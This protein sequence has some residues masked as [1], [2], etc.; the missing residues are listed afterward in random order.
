MNP[1]SREITVT[2][3]DETT[4]TENP[5]NSK[6]TYDSSNTHFR[7]TETFS[8]P[9]AKS[10]DVSLGYTR[11]FLQGDS[12]AKYLENIKLKVLS[13][14]VR[15]E[16]MQ[17]QYF[18]SRQPTGQNYNFIVKFSISHGV[19]V[20]IISMGV[21]AWRNEMFLEFLKATYV[22][23]VPDSSQIFQPT[24]VLL[25][26]PSGIGENLVS[27][28]LVAKCPTADYIESEVFFEIIEAPNSVTRIIVFF[29]SITEIVDPTTTRIYVVR[30]NCIL[31]YD[32]VINLTP[33]AIDIKLIV[34]PYEDQP[35][36]KINILPYIPKFE[37]SGFIFRFFAII[38]F[39]C[40]DSTIKAY[41]L[42]E[43]SPLEG[44]VNED[45][46]NLE[47]YLVKPHEG[48]TLYLSNSRQGVEK[49][50][51]RQREAPV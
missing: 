12:L 43:K 35:M 18:K 7:I 11:R 3:L 28:N 21:P 41:L 29:G 46:L 45:S 2:Y 32:S 10:W 31:R 37:Y 17:P 36:P 38:G 22:K 15:L 26:K 48:K 49:N 40:G 51:I 30:I 23:Q 24:N 50:T 20:F 4:E 8:N 16:L 1:G 5:D 39:T 6:K 9:I 19:H 34:I 33:K 44:I 42:L 27:E 47:F 25:G 13:G 14:P